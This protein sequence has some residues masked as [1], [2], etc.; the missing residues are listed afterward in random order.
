MD[1][2]E[3]IR[4]CEDLSDKM[5]TNEAADCIR[6]LEEELWLCRSAGGVLSVGVRC[7]LQRMYQD[8]HRQ[9]SSEAHS[10]PSSQQH[11]QSSSHESN[12]KLVELIDLT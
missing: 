9:P 5:T 8:E 11:Q 3:A 7:E 1:E 10:Q 2:Y 4:L 12:Q 6:R